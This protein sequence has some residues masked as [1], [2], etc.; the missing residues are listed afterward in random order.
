MSGGF[1]TYLLIWGELPTI[2]VNMLDYSDENIGTVEEQKE[3]FD[4]WR[5]HI[6]GE[7]N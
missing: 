7:K 3:Y 4:K 5:V 2:V 6:K 1:K